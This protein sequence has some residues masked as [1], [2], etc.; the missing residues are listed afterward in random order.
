MATDVPDAGFVRYVRSHLRMMTTRITLVWPQQ[1]RGKHHQRQQRVMTVLEWT[2]I[3]L[4]HLEVALFACLSTSYKLIP[5]NRPSH[6]LAYDTPPATCD[7]VYE[8]NTRL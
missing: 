8:T 2:P 5:S 4:C 6:L 7:L 3:L 1:L